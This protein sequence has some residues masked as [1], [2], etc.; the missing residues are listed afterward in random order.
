[1]HVT[2]TFDARGTLGV[3]RGVPVG[4]TDVDVRFELDTDAD[5]SAVERLLNLTERYCVVAQTL[6]TPPRL[7]VRST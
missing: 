6:T 1:M 2:G 3:E 5:P 7:R 4:L